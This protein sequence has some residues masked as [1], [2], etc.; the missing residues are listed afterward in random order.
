MPKMT[1]GEGLAKRFAGERV[2]V[3]TVLDDMSRPWKRILND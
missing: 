3:E 1:T 2:A